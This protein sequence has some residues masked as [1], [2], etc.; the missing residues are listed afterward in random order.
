MPEPGNQHWNTIT[1]LPL[2]K[3][4]MLDEL[5]HGLVTPRSLAWICEMIRAEIKNS[6]N[7]A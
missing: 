4:M 1:G 2:E 6:E 5:A 7:N 3:Q